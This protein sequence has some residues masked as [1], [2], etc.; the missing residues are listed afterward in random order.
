M[1]EAAPIYVPFVPNGRPTGSERLGLGQMSARPE[2]ARALNAPEQ[3]NAK[4][5]FSE[6]QAAIDSAF[7]QQQPVAT[8]QAGR[9]NAELGARARVAAGSQSNGQSMQSPPAQSQ[10][11]G[12]SSGDDQ[13]SVAASSAMRQRVEI[14]VRL[15]LP[16][17]ESGVQYNVVV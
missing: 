1:I 14:A 17:E 11:N 4:A 7:S 9:S 10:T 6:R 3:S 8:G 5:P 12:A 16:S 15:A 13:E 2:S